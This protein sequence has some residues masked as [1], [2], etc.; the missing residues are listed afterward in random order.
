[1]A[2]VSLL[3]IATVTVA[4][5]VVGC[6]GD[7]LRRFPDRPVAWYEHDDAPLAGDPREARWT[8]ARD[9]HSFRDGVVLEVDRMMR[10]ES[11][12]PAEDVN[13]LDEVPCSTWFCPR[14]H[15]AP[16]DA[17]ALRAGPDGFAAPVPPVTIRSGKRSG[18]SPGWVVEDARGRKFIMK[19]DPKG[20]LGLMSA[21]E[22]LGP[23]VF[24]A[25]G[26]NVPK[27]FIADLAREDIR[28]GDGATYK[29]ADGEKRPVTDAIVD[30]T[31]EAA[32]RT[33][34]GRIRFMFVSFLGGKILG[35]FDFIGTRQ[36]DPNDRIPHQ[37]R[38]SLRAS[39]VFY[40]WLNSIDGGANNTLDVVVEEHGRRFVRHYIVDFGASLGSL[41]TKPKPPPRRTWWRA[42]VSL[43]LPS[44]ALERRRAEWARDNRAYPG[45]GYIEAEG[46]DPARWRGNTSVPAHERMT[47]R[48]AYWGAKIVTSFTD[49][50]I[51]TLVAE[52][53][54]DER[55]ARH[56]ERVLRV[57]RD[58]IGRKYLLRM[59]ALEQPRL[60]AGRLCFTDLAVAR[61]LA[62]RA[63]I[64]YDVEVRGA[65]RG[66]F[67][68]QGVE[69][70]VPVGRAL[71][72]AR[73][74][75]YAVVSVR[76]KIDGR[77]ARRAH[78]HLRW[79]AGEKKWVIVG[80]DRD[81]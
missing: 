45:L 17:D 68:A 52:T 38:R 32:A 60:D 5:A 24:H 79:R 75:G 65:S 77:A 21:A 15:I 23:L 73:D 54:L 74:R 70:C 9:A 8:E 12:R 64:V 4:V 2:G 13:A 66:V 48:D 44:E 80:L 28:V 40:A 67:G 30:A 41:T 43:G 35:A 72:S 1:M 39:R 10:L 59:T 76:A 11:K 50:Q 56:L 61:K 81:E 78:V 51:A 29:D 55:H 36:D 16:L 18:Y 14:N 63:Q 46:W 62:T 37:H 26:Y 49:E 34:D 19:F 25:I 6:A 42:L 69:T 3:R 7:S 27:A 31:L 71:A 22:V 33:S 57:R 20:H 47:A 53:K 58:L